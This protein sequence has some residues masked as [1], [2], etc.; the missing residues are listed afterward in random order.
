MSKQATELADAIDADVEALDSQ[1]AALIP[2]TTADGN[3]NR[4]RVRVAIYQLRKLSTR[5]RKGYVPI[6]SLETARDQASSDYRTASKH[7]EDARRRRAQEA[8]S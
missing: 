7:L 6:R 3:I 4:N 5:L 8:H 1:Y 2:W